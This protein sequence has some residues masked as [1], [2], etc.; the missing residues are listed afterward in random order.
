LIAWQLAEVVFV[1]ARF[2]YFINL[3][4][5]QAGVPLGVFISAVLAR[6]LALVALMYCVV[7]EIRHPEGDDVRVGNGVDPAGGVLVPQA[8]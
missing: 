8:A 4:D 2:Q 5:P 1:V 6:D 3:S 7:R